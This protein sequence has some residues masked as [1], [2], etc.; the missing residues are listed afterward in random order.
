MTD[1]YYYTGITGKYILRLQIIGIERGG[2]TR[3]YNSED[4][5]KNRQKVLNAVQNTSIRLRITY[6]GPLKISNHTNS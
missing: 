3:K 1:L 2:R 4:N 5:T 6:F